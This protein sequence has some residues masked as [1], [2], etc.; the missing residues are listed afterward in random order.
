MVSGRW[1]SDGCVLS[2]RE[3][4]LEPSDSGSGSS[5]PVLWDYV[6]CE[7][8]HMT[9]F[10]VLMD[11]SNEEVRIFQMMGHGISSIQSDDDNLQCGKLCPIRMLKLI[12]KKHF[13]I[14]PNIAVIG[15]PIS[16]SVKISH[17]FFWAYDL[18]R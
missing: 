8:V 15:G 7:C 4:R 14:H 17:C 9:S 5:L 6:T 16:I 2:S 12:I 13:I 1:S 11:V 10:A 3:Q 18:Y